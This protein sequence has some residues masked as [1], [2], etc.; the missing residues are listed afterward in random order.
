M[1]RIFNNVWHQRFEKLQTKFYPTGSRNF[2]NFVKSVLWLME[3]TFKENKCFFLFVF[4]VFYILENHSLN[5]LY[6]TWIFFKTIMLKKVFVFFTS[7]TY[8][9][10][11]TT[12]VP[13][14]QICSNKLFANRIKLSH[15]KLSKTHLIRLMN[16]VIDSLKLY[17]N[18]LQIYFNW[19]ITIHRKLSKC[20]WKKNF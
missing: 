5:C 2:T 15:K 8:T 17:D 1:Y 9:G 14:K 20:F 13:R 7:W 16:Y 6:T 4:F 18:L 11:S 12:M 10:Y 19:R 3:I